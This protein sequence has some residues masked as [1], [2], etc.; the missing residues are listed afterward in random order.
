MFDSKVG[1]QLT[2]KTKNN[3]LEQAQPI[4]HQNS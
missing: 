3:L 2:G 1:K 4:L